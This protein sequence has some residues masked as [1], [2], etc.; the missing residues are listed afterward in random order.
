VPAAAAWPEKSTLRRLTKHQKRRLRQVVCGKQRRNGSP[1]WHMT[2]VMRSSDSVWEL[3]EL[4][5]IRIR[6]KV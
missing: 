6:S 2:V 3:E 5:W 4:L 1:R